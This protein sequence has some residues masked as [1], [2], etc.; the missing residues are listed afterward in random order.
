METGNEKGW[1][2]APA[3]IPERDSPAWIAQRDAKL[4]AW[5]DA[6]TALEDAKADEMRLRKEFV[7]FT[8]D[9]N[10]HEGTERVEL[11][12]GYEAKVVKKCNYVFISPDPTVDVADAVDNALNQLE[13]AG[14][15]GKFV[16]GRLV[17]WTPTLSLTEYRNLSPEF[18]TIVDK[19]IETRDGAPT[20]D[21]IPPKGTKK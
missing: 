18:K 3:A 8:F 11:H 4:K 5:E 13:Q 2:S 16:A 15:E 9:P 19:V 20:L 14:P 7:D 6:K 1:G 10:R 17:K 12:N 21:I